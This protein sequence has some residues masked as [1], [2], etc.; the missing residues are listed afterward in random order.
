MQHMKHSC[1][2][3]SAKV[4]P[5]NC[6]AFTGPTKVDCRILPSLVQFAMAGL[7]PTEMEEL[8]RVIA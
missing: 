7:F 2:F 6:M 1:S 4:C 5:K 3:Y 8:L